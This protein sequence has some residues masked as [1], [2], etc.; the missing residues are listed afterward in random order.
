[1]YRLIFLIFIVS[2][3]ASLHQNE[4]YTNQFGVYINQFGKK[5]EKTEYN[6]RLEVFRNALDFIENENRKNHTYMLGFSPFLDMTREEFKSSKISSCLLTKNRPSLRKTVKLDTSNI[7]S[8][9]NWVTRGAVNKVKNQQ[10]CGSC[11]AFSAV[12]SIESVVAIHTGILYS[13]SEQNLIDCDPNNHGCSGGTMENAFLFAINRPGLC[14]ESAYPYEAISGTCRDAYCRKVGFIGDYAEVEE[15]NGEQLLA[16]IALNPVSLALEADSYVFQYYVSGIINEE[17]CGT[18]INHG[19]VAVGYETDKVSTI[20]YIL[21]R[22]CWGSSWGMEGYVKIAH[23][24]K[25]EGICGM[26][27]RASYPIY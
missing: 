18:F 27:T 17:S 6:Y 16:A 23:Q 4:F 7:P 12:G 1:M 21:I 11:W 19:V 15:N 5:Y 10:N 24:D 26:N 13:I 9:V 2:V 20:P 25:G 22:N 8:S 14:T 3:F